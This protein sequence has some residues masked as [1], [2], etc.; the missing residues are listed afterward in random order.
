MLPPIP[1]SDT[2]VIQD[3]IRQNGLQDIPAIRDKIVFAFNQRIVGRL[4]EILTPAEAEEFLGLTENAAQGE[5]TAQA[6]AQF[7]Q[8]YPIYEAEIQKVSQAVYYEFMV[9]EPADMIDVILKSNGIEE[10]DEEMKS[11]LH[12]VIEKTFDDAILAT[13]M[14]NIS[15]RESDQLS[16]RIQESP[17]QSVAVLDEVIKEHHLESEVALAM[18]E[19]YW[20]LVC[21]PKGLL[22]EQE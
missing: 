10:L 3:I 12:Q 4:K 11:Q 18:H 16:I 1:S 8:K 7:L 13:V 9:T 15:I 19:A 17:G 6:L 20:S 14:K 2:A 21:M 5:E 22:T